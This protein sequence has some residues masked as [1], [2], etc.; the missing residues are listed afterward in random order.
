MERADLEMAVWMTGYRKV[1]RERGRCDGIGE[2][3]RDVENDAT[4][5]LL[6]VSQPLR[7][8]PPR[9]VTLAGTELRFYLLF[10]R[11]RLGQHCPVINLM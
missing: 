6:V 7:R 9:L 1:E 2:E 4:A 3:G 8:R 11:W 10:L 5:H